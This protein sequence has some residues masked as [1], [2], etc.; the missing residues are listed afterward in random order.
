MNEG[1]FRIASSSV[2]AVCRER[3]ESRRKFG[4]SSSLSHPGQTFDIFWP[5]II[6]LAWPIDQHSGEENKTE[7]KK[8]QSDP[9]KLSQTNRQ[10]TIIII[11]TTTAN[12][13][14]TK[15]RRVGCSSQ[16]FPRG[17]Q[18]PPDSSAG[19]P[20]PK[21]IQFASLGNGKRD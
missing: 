14:F 6:Y 8:R 1:E 19:E 20:A 18:R 4:L 2:R 21:Q 5:S 13:V 16:E 10:L 7:Y 15:E 9:A 3:F 17:L 12:C 11:T